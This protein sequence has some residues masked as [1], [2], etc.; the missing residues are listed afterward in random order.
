MLLFIIL[1][2]LGGI[3]GII[4]IASLLDPYSGGEVA[5]GLFSFVLGLALFVGGSIGA[6]KAVDAYNQ[7]TV[8]LCDAKDGTVSMDGKCMVDQKPVEFSPGVWER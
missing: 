5:F 1:V 3:I 8:K 4:G 6:N 7:E 2:V